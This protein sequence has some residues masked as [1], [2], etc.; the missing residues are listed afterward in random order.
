VIP[1]L[2]MAVKSMKIGEKALVVVSTKYGYKVL[3]MKQDLK[4]QLNRS[5]ET[6]KTKQKEDQIPEEPEKLLSELEPNIA[7]YYCTLTY[8]IEL[9]KHDKPRKPKSQ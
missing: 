8:E 1:G 7:K 2:E 6:E 3:K 9:L 5:T 4:K